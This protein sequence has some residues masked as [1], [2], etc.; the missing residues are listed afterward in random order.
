MDSYIVVFLGW[1]NSQAFAHR[2]RPI[3]LSL[4]IIIY[5]V[6]FLV[7]VF[8]LGR[9]WQLIKEERVRVRTSPWRKVEVAIKEISVWQSFYLWWTRQGG[10]MAVKSAVPLDK[11]LWRSPFVRAQVSGRWTEINTNAK[12]MRRHTATVLKSLKENDSLKN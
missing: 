8:P 4:L 11:S 12:R 1:P 5:Q 2:N 9:G 7:S 10:A 6:R 3:D